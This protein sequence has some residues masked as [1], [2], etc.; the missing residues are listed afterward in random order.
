VSF[1]EVPDLKDLIQACLIDSLLAVLIILLS[2]F[3]WLTVALPKQQTIQN[4]KILSIKD[5]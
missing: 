5:L 2:I 4:V 3:L 1:A